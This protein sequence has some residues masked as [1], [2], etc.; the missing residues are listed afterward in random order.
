[1]Y[2][3]CCSSG[4]KRIFLK[5]HTSVPFYWMG[6]HVIKSIWL[7]SWLLLKLLPLFLKSTFF[8]SNNSIFFYITYQKLQDFFSNLPQILW[9][10]QLHKGDNPA[11]RSNIL[12]G[13]RYTAYQWCWVYK[14]TPP[15]SGH[16]PH[17]LTHPHHSHM[18]YNQCQ[19]HSVHKIHAE[20]PNS[21]TP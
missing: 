20:R 17:W 14:Y 9:Q 12:G 5:I 19:C 18:V 11:W 4:L 10:V 3:F 6:M 8:L 2:L 15:L 13:A 21:H 16:T 1:M 7:K